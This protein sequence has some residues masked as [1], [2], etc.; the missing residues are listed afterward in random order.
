MHEIADSEQ[1]Y[2]EIKEDVEYSDEG[3]DVSSEEGEPDAGEE[4]VVDS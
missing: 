1:K 4:R 3:E 2:E